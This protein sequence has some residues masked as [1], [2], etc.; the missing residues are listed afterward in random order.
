MSQEDQAWNIA[1]IPASLSFLD[2][3]VENW[4]TRVGDDV[5]PEG[6]AGGDN[7]TILVPGRRA[8][9]A[10]MEAFLR[11]LDGKAALLP[12]IVALGDVDEQT[13]FPMVLD[14]AVPP[15]VES[16]RRLAVLSQLILSAPFFRS[17]SGPEGDTL[18]RVWPL[19][20]ALAELMDEAERNE[21]DLHEA[22]PRAV[23]EDFADHWQK[24]LT[25]LK[26]VTEFWPKILREEGRSNIMARQV[27]Q[28]GRAHV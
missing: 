16:V 5:G 17:V 18:D 8:A 2:Q 13:L 26:I 4:L 25:F 3:V 28:I 9:R 23:A 10:L 12:S 7:G 14:E 11:V 19:A 27:A 22:L 15:A 1:T 20:Q 21:V 24:T 6:R